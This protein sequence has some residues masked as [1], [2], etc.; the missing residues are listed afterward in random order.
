MNEPIVCNAKAKEHR[1]SCPGFV[2]VLRLDDIDLERGG[3]WREGIQAF[4]KHK[5]QQE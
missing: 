4:C 1:M 2:P 5:D 3:P